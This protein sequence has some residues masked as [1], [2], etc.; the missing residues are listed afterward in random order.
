[1]IRFASAIQAAPLIHDIH[2]GADRVR[3]ALL[4]I[5]LADIRAMIPGEAIEG[6]IASVHGNPTRSDEVVDWLIVLITSYHSPS[7]RSYCQETRDGEIESSRS[8]L[9]ICSKERIGGSCP[10]GSEWEIT[11]PPSFA[12]L[13]RIAAT[14]SVRIAMRLR[15]L[16]TSSPS[17]WLGS[18][19]IQTMIDAIPG[20][21]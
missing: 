13:M 7:Q 4:P 8:I 11:P 21:A 15:S 9:M 19:W 16:R 6:W 18:D 3:A 10:W 14:E 17:R 20:T 1:M 12:D 5:C 2:R